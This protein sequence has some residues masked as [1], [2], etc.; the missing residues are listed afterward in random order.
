[1]FDTQKVPEVRN[2]GL[3]V[4]SPPLLYLHIKNECYHAFLHLICL[5]LLGL[6]API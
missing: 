6:L 3:A 5:Q 4:C 1:M 2:I